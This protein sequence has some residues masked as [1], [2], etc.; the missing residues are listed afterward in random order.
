MIRYPCP[1]RAK[2]ARVPAYCFCG[3][4]DH[5]WQQGGALWAAISSPEMRSGLVIRRDPRG[6]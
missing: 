6:P 2:R 4:L 3:L 5:A 1:L